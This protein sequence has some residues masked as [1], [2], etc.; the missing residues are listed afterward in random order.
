[1]SILKLIKTGL[2]LP[3]KPL[4]KAFGRVL[5]VSGY[6]WALDWREPMMLAL[7][8]FGSAAVTV[9]YDAINVAQT[10]EQLDLLVR[11]MWGGF[12]AGEIT[13]ADTEF[14]QSCIQRRRPLASNTQRTASGRSVGQLAGRIGRRLIPR[15]R[16]RSPNRKA[17]RDRRRTLGSSAVMPPNLR[18]YY[19]EGQRAVL[20]II[21]GE[22]K[23]HGICEL[24]LDKIAALAG[25]C[26]TT[27]QTTLHEARRLFH[28]I[29]TE[30]PQPGGKSLTNVVEII[31]RE[32][33][34]WI[35]RGPAAHRP[36]GSNS[37][38]MVSPT[39][40]TDKQ[41]EG[42]ARVEASRGAVRRVL[43]GKPPPLPLCKA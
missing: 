24:P 16:P 14:L 41:K 15:Q 37:V 7:R 10:S 11:T 3:V 4:A 6:V 32:W 9:L 38:R 28:I 43:L 29:V 13:E 5:G 36:V 18:S 19:T 1:V 22:I 17:S 23:H 26:R 8:E 21:A 30:R 25:V 42:C 2:C 40:S 33:M 12:C 27:V 34:T 35:R 31:S 39:K 20:A